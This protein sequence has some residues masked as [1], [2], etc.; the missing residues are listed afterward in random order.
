MIGNGL[1]FV[2][3]L[4]MLEGGV[5]RNTFQVSSGPFTSVLRQLPRLWS[6]VASAGFW[7]EVQRADSVPLR[8]AGSRPRRDLV[9]LHSA[10]QS[11]F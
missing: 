9:G 10:S 8:T 4:Q 2:C 11:H 3:V 5:S 1:F 6:L 7:E